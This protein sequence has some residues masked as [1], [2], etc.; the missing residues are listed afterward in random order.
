VKH[1][2]LFR[3]EIAAAFDLASALELAPH[4][5]KLSSKARWLSVGFL[6]RPRHV[7]HPCQKRRSPGIITSFNRSLQRTAC[8]RFIRSPALGIQSTGRILYLPCVSKLRSFLPF[9]RWQP[10]TKRPHRFSRHQAG[11]AARRRLA[12]FNITLITTNQQPAAHTCFLHFFANHEFQ[13]APQPRAPY[14]WF[15]MQQPLQHDLQRPGR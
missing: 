6:F 11:C 13:S 12:Q 9:K 1:H 7:A 4:A 15:Q 5:F 8:F 2:F 14:Q 3:F 10:F